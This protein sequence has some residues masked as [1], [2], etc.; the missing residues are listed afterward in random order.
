MSGEDLK[1][2]LVRVAVHDERIKALEAFKAFM[3]RI[4]WLIGTGA[5]GV[6]MS[7]ILKQAGLM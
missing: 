5:I 4:M 6:V 7:V 1:S 3:M 2:L